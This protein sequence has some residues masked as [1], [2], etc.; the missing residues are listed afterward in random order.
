MLDS[1]LDSQQGFACTTTINQNL[2][3]WRTTR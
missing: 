2:Y 1:T 3:K